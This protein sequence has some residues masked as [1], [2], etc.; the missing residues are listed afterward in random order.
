MHHRL[1]PRAHQFEYGIFLACL[2]LDELEAL[3]ARLRF[4]SRNRRNWLEFRDSD[5]LPNPEESGPKNQENEHQ[6]PNIKRALQA[7]LRQQGV[8]LADND[9]VLLLTLP[10]IAGYVFN[11][12][13]FYFC[14]KASGE[15]LCAVAEVGNTFGEIETLPSSPSCRPRRS[16]QPRIPLRGAQTLLRLALHTAG[17]LLRFPAPDSRTPPAHRRQRRQPGA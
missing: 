11:P 17:C 5:H 6:K 8:S 16:R 9:R 14:T 15:A 2:D 1:E 10:R 4:F 13:S 12:V 7:W 3:D